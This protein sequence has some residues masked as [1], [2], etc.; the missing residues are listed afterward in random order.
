M[1]PKRD[2]SPKPV[3]PAEKGDSGKD[4]KKEAEKFVPPPRPAGLRGSLLTLYGTLAVAVLI[5]AIIGESMV[6][7]VP[8]GKYEMKD[9]KLIDIL[10]F[11]VDDLG[12]Y[13]KCHPHFEE[14]KVAGEN[15][16]ETW[17]KN[18]DAPKGGPFPVGHPE[19][20]EWV[21]KAD[22]RTK[23]DNKENRFKWKGLQ[24]N[25]QLLTL[26]S[27]A[28]FLGSKHSV[29]AFTEPAETREA[30][31]PVLQSEDA[32]WFPVMGSGVLFGLFITLKYLGTYWVKTAITAWILF[33]CSGG[34]GKN[35]DEIVAVI[36]MKT[37]KPLF[38]IPYF[39]EDV[40]P[41]QIVG[42]A[43]GA[44]MAGVY[45][46][47][48]NWICN[49]IFGLSF[50]LLG[51]RMIGLSSV[52]VGAIMLVGLFFYDVFWVFGSKSVF[53][54]NVMV[55]VA[56]GV[57]APIKLMFPR[58]LSGCGLLRNGMLGLGDIVVPGIFVAFLAKWDAVKMGEKASSSFVYLNSVMVAYVLSLVTTVSIM[59]FFNA[60]QPA[61]LY[62]VPFVLITTAGVAIVRGEFKAL[63]AFEIPDES[64]PE[65][66][67][68]TNGKEDKKKD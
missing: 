53:G 64:A 45:F 52:K 8:E 9:G 29:W 7:P 13:P 25:I 59:M 12:P 5:F 28:V 17:V 30:G 21:K 34:L 26:A 44:A 37:M 67:K 66:E 56:M 40:K 33:I 38:R 14:H 11:P 24:P 27:L 41:L 62:I 51:I 47:S 36:R 46:Y 49:N 3:N 20:P 39:D 32:Y 50:C 57:E 10:D 58:E 15:G 68:K 4:G 54:S 63:W 18:A 65:D 43:V 23:A 55:S 6:H 16:T 42:G 48:Q 35:V 31:A 61:L 60:A 1:A 22:E 19:N 2:Q